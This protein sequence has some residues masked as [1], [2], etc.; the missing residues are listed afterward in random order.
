MSSFFTILPIVLRRV[1]ANGRLLTAVVIGAVLAAALMSTTSIYTDAIRDLGLSYAIRQRGPNEINVSIQSGS[2]GSQKETYDK[3]LE[4]IEASAG[5]AIGPLVRGSITSGG[6][7]STFFPTPPGSAVAVNDDSRYRSH[8]QFLTGIDTHIRVT[9]GRFPT[10]IAAAPAGSPPAIEVAIGADTARRLNL[11]IGQRFDLHPFWALEGAPLPATIVGFVEPI[12]LDEPYWRGQTDLFSFPT[13]RWETLPFFITEATFFD[14]VVAYLPTMTSDFSGFVYLDTSR[15]DARNAE[16]V[17][18]SLLAF[19]D[20]LETTI[21]RTL[22]ETVLPGILE[23]YDEKLFFTRIPLLVLVLQIA[24]IVLYYLFMVSTMLIERQASEIALL[25]S[26]GA[27]TSQVMHI[28]AV[29]GLVILLLA[30]GLGPP[31]AALVISLLGQTPPF[32]D[33]SGGSNL[34]VRLTGAAYLWAA[35]GAVLAYATLLWP[36]YQA[37]RSTVVQQRTSSARPPKQ[38]VF[39]RYYL[40]PV[41][42]GLGGLLFYQLNRRGSLVTNEIFGEQS[43]DPIL[44]LTPAFF[45]LTI[46]I[47]FLRLFPLV[48]RG[49]AW[50]VARAQGTAVLIGMWQLVRNPVHYSRLVLLLMLATAVGMFAASFGATLDRSYADRAGYESGSELRIHQIRRADISGPND[51]AP[52]LAGQVA[53]EAASPVM[54]VSG[55]LGGNVFD[56]TN[57]TILG[58]EPETFTDVAFLRDDYASQ[59]LGSMLDTLAEDTQPGEP[60]LIP[61]DAR[62]L[63]VWLNPT[64]LRGRIGLELRARDATGRYLSFNLGPDNGAELQPGWTFLLADLSRPAS[65]TGVTPFVA[66]PPQAPMT[67]VSLSVR[68]FTRVSAGGGAM[69]LDNLIVSSEAPAGSLA[70]SRLV[71]DRERTLQPFAE[72]RSLATFDDPAAWQPIGGLTP[73]ALNDEVRQ[74]PGGA[75][76]MQWRPA[77][78]PQAGTHGLRPRAEDRPL[79]VLASEAFLTDAGLA[80][81]DT[82]NMFVNNSYIDVEIAGSYRLFPTLLDPRL[83][84]SLVANGERLQALINGNP[85]APLTYADEVW[86][87]PGPDSLAQARALLRDGSTIASL[88]SFEEIRA[89]QES[90]PLVAAGWEGILL[91]SFAAILLLSALGFLIYSYLTAQKRTLEFAVLRTM[92]FSRRQI[93]TVV[94]FE[95]VFV[96]G[97]GMAAGTVMGLR[98]GALMIRYMG[99]S[100]TGGEVLPPMLLHVSWWTIGAAW[101]VLSAAFMVT[102]GIIVLLYSR[103]S[104]SRVLRIGEA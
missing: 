47:V 67:V 35:A 2:Q 79:A 98:L 39:T 7:S 9:E 58:I 5:Q 21:P 11:S 76:E 15:V 53:A 34:S 87:K 75:I 92:G 28:Y 42:V 86:L 63:G 12:D 99:V 57:F 102:I 13:D 24:G 93:A 82:G 4:L 51:L 84:S 88:V 59:S 38:P 23:S 19:K 48:L 30:L 85:R 6:R 96:I 89:A 103:L 27:T 54:R 33:L 29:E 74:I 52:G 36:A 22:V 95:Q 18:V 17:R 66:S 100:E 61:D 14:A 65:D 73:Q 3:N 43:V 1:R 90:D 62:W 68:F 71:L 55:S 60:L 80:V 97:L 41:L 26:R 32:A 46:G 78:S 101:L 69:Q 25:K 31:L 49:L 104:L 45:I 8:L 40:D 70:S 37:T 77:G 72:P 94:G 64:D 16:S 83:E 20:Q 50:V 81:G 10:D 44:L 91:I 56:R